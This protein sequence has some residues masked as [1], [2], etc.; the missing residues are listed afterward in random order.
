MTPPSSVLLFVRAL[1][2]EVLFALALRMRAH[3]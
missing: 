2:A 3:F 1:A